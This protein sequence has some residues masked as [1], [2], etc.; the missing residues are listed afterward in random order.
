MHSSVRRGPPR[1]RTPT[2]E[3]APRGAEVDAVRTAQR[4]AGNAAVT[5]VL[6]RK[7]A[8]REAEQLRQYYAFLV[9]TRDIAPGAYDKVLERII[10]RYELYQ[11]AATQLSRSSCRSP[12]VSSRPRPG[13]TLPGTSPSS[14]AAWA[15][16]PI[17]RAEARSRCRA[18]AGR[19]ATSTSASTPRPA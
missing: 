3:E 1:D 16:C 12:R 7:L 11:D 19:R 5:R 17:W 6:Q 10:E 9:D 2:H 8:E 15:L 18:A 4:A 14:S 13:S